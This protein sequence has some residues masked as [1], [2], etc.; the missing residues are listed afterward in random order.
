MSGKGCTYQFHCKIVRSTEGRVVAIL[1]QDNSLACDSDAAWQVLA[2]FGNFLAWA[3]AGVGSAKLEGEG[4]GMI[5]HLDIPG[6]G[7]VSERLDMLD[8]ASRSLTYTLVSE[9]VAGMARYSATVQVISDGKEQ[10][11]LRWRG[12]FEPLPGTDSDEVRNSLAGFYS[13]MS[14]GLEAYVNTRT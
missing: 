14:Q 9:N 4:V 12:E 1:E 3:T 8:P 10:C 7:L 5:R 2:D 13:T 11:R 6:L